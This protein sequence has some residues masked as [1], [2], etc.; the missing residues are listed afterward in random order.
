MLVVNHE[1]SSSTTINAVCAQKITISGVVQG[2]GF[3]PFV[4]RLAQ[5][6]NVSGWVN[7]QGNHLIIFCQGFRKNIGSF[8]ND[9]KTSSP[10]L[11]KITN[12]QFETSLPKKEIEAFTIKTS[13]EDFNDIFC[14]NDYA[15]CENCK[16]ELFDKNNR[17]YLHPFI[18]CSECGPRH[19]ITTQFPFDRKNTS[20]D[21]FSLCNK[22]REEYSDP[23][24]RRFHTQ[25]ICCNDCG[26]EYVMQINEN[27]YS[28]IK[29]ILSHTEKLLNDG[30]ILAIKC[31]S[32]YR[33]FCDANNSKAIN[34]LRLKKHRPQ[35]PLALM[36]PEDEKLNLLRNYVEIS[37]KQKVLLKDIRRPIVLLNNRP[38]KSLLNNISDN[39]SN[40]GV[41]LPGNGFEHLLLN[42]VNKP[43]VATSANLTNQPIISDTDIA[44]KELAALCDAFIH[45]NLD[46]ENSL[47]DSIFLENLAPARL[48]RGFSPLEFWLPYNLPEPVAALGSQM[49]NTVALAWKNR[50]VI[51]AHN[52]NLENYETS[53]FCLRRLNNL[54]KIYQVKAKNYLVDAHPDHS[55]KML[56]K[57]K[58]KKSIEIYHHHAHASAIKIFMPKNEP[59]LIFTWDGTGS[60]VNNELWGAE[61]FFGD[62]GNWKRVASFKP[63]LL[64]GGT[65]A[66]EQPWRVALSLCLHSKVEFP[67]DKP[68]LPLVKQQWEKRINSPATSSI[69][70][71][72]DAAA[73]LLG[74][75]QESN[76]DAQAAMY[77][78][79]AATSKTNNYISLPILQLNELHQ[80]DWSPLVTMLLDDTQ[81]IAY[82][83]TVFHNSLVNAL[84]QQTTLFAKKYRIINIGLSGGVFQNQLLTIKTKYQ[85]EIMGFCVHVCEKIPSNDANISLGQILEYAAKHEI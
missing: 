10:K 24:N 52:G 77:L 57:I 42:H 78:E 82:R 49:K 1:T 27:K 56:F 30:K 63:F 22:C 45:H 58:H 36:F 73:A 5:K 43:L 23:K 55:A 74:L 59:A 47:D 50:I 25:N 66:I 14:A 6:H 84:C 21:N 34:V 61:T 8:N 31:T 38:R 76:F 48:A 62:I 35:K 19:S 20:Y 9:L 60:G 85:L 70:R 18:S 16:Q 28:N 32:G 71:L 41:M 15:L 64:P 44:K 7:N 2:V 67:F 72:F 54:E 79:A 4:Y 68:T 39:L 40:V 83:A 13:T 65:L 26:P 53:Q 37:Q 11:A 12:I 3:R 51:S 33:L 46:I 17:R 80:I 29:D 81:T 75:I 69:G